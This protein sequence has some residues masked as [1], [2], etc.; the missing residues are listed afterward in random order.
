MGA[1]SKLANSAASKSVAVVA[2]INLVSAEADVAYDIRHVAALARYLIST[3]CD[4]Y[5]VGKPQQGEAQALHAYD[6]CHVCLYMALP[7]PAMPMKKY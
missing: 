4:L 7:R 2:V 1:P 3:Y 6:L 5:L